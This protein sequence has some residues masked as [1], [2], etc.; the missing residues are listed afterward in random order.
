MLTREGQCVLYNHRHMH[1]IS[2][3]Y[4]IP[5]TKENENMK[6]RQ[7]LKMTLG[8]VKFV[9]ISSYQRTFHI[10]TRAVESESLKVGKSLKIGKNQIKSENTDLIS[11]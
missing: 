6:E 9:S 7:N 10:C 2:P 11:Y 1:T 3:S 4:D 5:V 8:N